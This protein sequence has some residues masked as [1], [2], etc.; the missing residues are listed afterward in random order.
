[1]KPGEAPSAAALREMEEEIGCLGP[2][3]LWLV[4]EVRS[5]AIYLTY[6]NGQATV[7]ADGEHDA[8]AWVAV[9]DLPHYPL[10]PGVMSCL[11]LALEKYSVCNSS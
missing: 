3:A 4:G 5:W 6:D 7:L 10:A 11:T 2:R 8:F 1:M 9:E